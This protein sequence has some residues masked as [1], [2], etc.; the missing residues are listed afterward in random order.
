MPVDRAWDAA[1]RSSAVVRGT[2][3]RGYW[4]RTFG[5]GLLFVCLLVVVAVVVLGGVLAVLY[6]V[7]ATLPAKMISCPE[8]DGCPASNPDVGQAERADDPLVDGPAMTP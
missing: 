3:G 4:P 7:T 5:D 2:P 6:S 8:L 1:R